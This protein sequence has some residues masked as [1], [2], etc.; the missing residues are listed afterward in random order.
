MHLRDLHYLPPDTTH[1][2]YAQRFRIVE[3]FAT[4]KRDHTASH[5]PRA[6]AYEYLLRDHQYSYVILAKKDR[7]EPGYP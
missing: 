5:L 2:L 3:S 7:S 1:C 4:I 6:H